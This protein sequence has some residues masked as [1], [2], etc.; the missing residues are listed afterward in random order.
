MA[1]KQ[2]NAEQMES[3]L[4]AAAGGDPKEWT[5]A[6]LRSIPGLAPPDADAPYSTLSELDQPPYP[7]KLKNKPYEAEL[8][9]LQIELAKMQASTVKAGDR[10]LAI[11][12]G[13]DAAGKGGVIKRI[14]E[15]LPPTR[16][17]HVA[18]PKPT[19]VE[20]TEWYFQRYVAHLPGG[21]YIS[22]FDRSW[23]NRAGVEPVLGFCTADQYAH[24]LN[25]V[26]IFETLLVR[27]GIQMHKFYFTLSKEEEQRRFESRLTDPLK[28]WKYSP[29]DHFSVERHGAYVRARNEMMLTTDTR[30]APWTLINGNEKKRARLE[31]IRYLLWVTDYEGK[32]EEVAHEPDRRVVV[33][34]ARVKSE[35]LAAQVG[36]AMT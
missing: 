20:K 29:T 27:D 11:Y 34:A 25:Q 28:K 3:D 16:V 4:V 36:G 22:L 14:L 6:R 24:F 33:P 17:R 7:Q 23:Y 35:L 2:R 5:T 1:R 8:L 21:G 13:L 12:E 30:D 15:Y 31:S 18:L 26:P 32:D 9:R 19:D 10:I